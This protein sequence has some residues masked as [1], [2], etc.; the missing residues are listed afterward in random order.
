MGRKKD[1]CSSHYVA[2]FYCEVFLAPLSDLVSLFRLWRKFRQLRPVIVDVHM[3]KPGL[4]GSIAVG[5]PA[6][7]IKSRESS[8]SIL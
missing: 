7:V 4:I 1:L 8:E 3:N 6:C 5:V 2:W